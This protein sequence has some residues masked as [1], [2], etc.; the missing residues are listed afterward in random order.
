MSSD[1][2]CCAERRLLAAAIRD[3]HR[4]GVKAHAV[5]T[6]VRRKLGGGDMTVWR[7]VRSAGSEGFG[8]STPCV[9]CRRMLLAFG[10]RVHCMTA[11]GHWFHGHL[12]EP[13]A[14]TSLPTSGQLRRLSF[15]PKDT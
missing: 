5:V 13:G 3:A 8:T 10:V 9:L 6:W 12:D 14:P 2:K 11:D 4:H 1:A 15:L 7:P